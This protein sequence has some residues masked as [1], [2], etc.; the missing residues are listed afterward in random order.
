[1]RPEVPPLPYPVDALEPYVSART[2][3]VHYEEHHK[4]YLHKLL[5]Q[6]EHA[7][8]SNGNHSLDHLV[9]QPARATYNNAAQVWNHNFYW[10]SLRPPQADADPHGP[11]LELVEKSFGSARTL[12]RQFA[13]LASDHFAS[14]WAWLVAN[15]EGRLALLTTPDAVNPLI[16]GQRPLLAIDL[17]E[18]AYYLDHHGERSRHL[19]G[20]LDHLLNW[21]FAAE[22][23]EARAARP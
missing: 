19:Q 11:L 20:V 9:L 8:Q 5:E 6:L 3:S 17:W 1:M 7:P 22:N 13:E 14:G 10:R 23:L 2:V 15:P 4:G 18:H 12:R 16:Q 21:D